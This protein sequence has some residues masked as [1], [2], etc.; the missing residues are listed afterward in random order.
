MRRWFLLL[1]GPLIWAA[2]FLAIYAVTSIW[3]IAA[4]ATDATARIVIVS[5]SAAAL[6]ATGFVTVVALRQPRHDSI[7]SFLRTV[8]AVGAIL[9]A[10][11]VTWQTLPALAPIEGTALEQPS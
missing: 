6:V 3:Y 9:A 4:G 11:A 2:H 10:I 1:G 7:D 5:L 8:A